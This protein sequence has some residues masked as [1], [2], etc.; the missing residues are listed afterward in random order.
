MNTSTAKTLE[1]CPFCDKPVTQHI[2][3][4]TFYPSFIC[5]HPCNLSMV[6]I[7]ATAS[8]AEH[9]A[10]AWNLR[11]SRARTQ[12]AEAALQKINAIRNSI[13]AFQTINWSEHIYP[14]VA[15][16]EEA[17][18]EGMDYPEA[19]ANVG[20][21]LERTLKAE[22][23]LDEA[24]K[25]IEPFGGYMGDHGDLDNNGQPLPDEQGVGWI[26]LKQKHFRAA[27]NW[28]EKNNG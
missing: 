18:I 11:A 22:A 6:A 17:G 2:S 27:S 28:M 19:K 12:T 26:Y 20:T 8:S 13:I 5:C 15:A 14:L 4:P 7:S 9:L 1:P 25:V 21:T 23:G 10:A 16:L 24:R 3:G